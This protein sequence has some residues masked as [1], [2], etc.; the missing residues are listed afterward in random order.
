MKVL[1]LRN[2]ELE[3]SEI[4]SLTDNITLPSLD[5]LKICMP[6]KKLPYK[7]Y[8]PVNA[9]KILSFNS[10]VLEQVQ[11]IYCESDHETHKQSLI[12]LLKSFK[13]KIVPL[14]DIRDNLLSNIDV[15]LSV[16]PSFLQLS[17][18]ILVNCSLDDSQLENLLNIELD[19][20]LETI[21]LDFNKITCKGA[22]TVSQLMGKCTKLARLSLSCNQVGDQGAIALCI[23]CT[24]PSPLSVRAGLG[25]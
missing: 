15:D 1:D 7:L 5:I 13:C 23:W 20:S 19:K 25:G 14:C 12:H 9:L 21:R 6:L 16:V 24:G 10:S 8:D 3:K 18:L 2:T 11:Y 22:A 17:R 4:T